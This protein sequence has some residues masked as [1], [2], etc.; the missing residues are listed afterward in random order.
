MNSYI[1]FVK[2]EFMENAR[3]YRLLIMIALFTIFGMLGP[4]S[5]KFMPELIAS[6]APD[7]EIA[8]TEPTALDSWVQFY[9]NISQLGFSVMIILFSGCL[10]SEY[11]KGTLNIMLTK[12]LSRPAVVMAKYTVAA[13]IMT[14]SYWLCFGITYGYT[15]YLWPG[16][17][18]LHTTFA[19]LALWVIGFM[20][21]SILMLGC[22]FFRQSFTSI[23]F[24]LVVTVFMSLVSIPT[25]IAGYS[26]LVLTSENVDLLAG[27][28]AT[29]DFLVPMIVALVLIV[30]LLS[31]A[32]MQF[33]KK[34]L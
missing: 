21:L 7:L 32:V 5:A 2:K 19:A 29:S 10:S 8:I 28:A 16:T 12:G 22:V 26:P 6:L 1:A 25:S 3:N 15:A 31:A 34:K 11:T 27:N 18:L 13:A 9:K 14:I 17:S 20:Y 30:G 33:N 23:V 4:L 24:L